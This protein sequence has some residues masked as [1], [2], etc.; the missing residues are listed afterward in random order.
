MKNLILSVLVLIAF[1]ASFVWFFIVLIEASK[2]SALNVSSTCEITTQAVL[3]LIAVIPM[4]TVLSAAK[5]IEG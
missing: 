1:P 4:I 5:Q 2:P 3:M